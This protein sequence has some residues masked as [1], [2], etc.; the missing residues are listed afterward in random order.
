[1]TS[2]DPPIATPY[3]HPTLI[4]RPLSQ[5]KYKYETYKGSHERQSS[6]MVQMEKYMM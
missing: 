4:A 2:R 3:H 6:L 5:N 1:M